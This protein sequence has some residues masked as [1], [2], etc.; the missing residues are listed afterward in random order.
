MNSEGLTMSLITAGNLT[1]IRNNF[2][3]T[4]HDECKI[5]SNASTQNSYGE[6][7][8]SVS[9]SDAVKCALYQNG[10]IKSV[11]GQYLQTDSDATLRLPLSVSV[12]FDSLI[13]I[14]SLYGST[15]SILYRVNSEPKKGLAGQTVELKRVLT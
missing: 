1:I 4:L 8:N 11:Q 9:Y 15:T 10:G 13:E 7:I 12:S 6:T 5:G 3:N 14:T 2:N